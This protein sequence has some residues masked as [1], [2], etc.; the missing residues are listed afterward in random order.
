MGE[1]IAQ[2]VIKGMQR[3]LSASKFNPDYAYENMN[4]RIT[5]REGKNLLSITNEKGNLEMVIL[6]SE[7]SALTI[8]GNFM[9][10][11]VLNNIIT[12]FTHN[13]YDRIYR[14]IYT[15]STNSFVG[16]L[17]YDGSVKGNIGFDL[18]HP[19][20]TLGVY[21]NEDIQKVYWVDGINQPR[22]INVAPSVDIT[23]FL[24]SSFDFA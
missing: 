17:L 23:K 16:T 3:D 10:R 15:P 22:F 7:G 2:F 9:G 13:I 20:E 18:L 4:I 5:A 24:K 21:E 1:K 12:I 19:I 8:T 14:L 11:N 6:D